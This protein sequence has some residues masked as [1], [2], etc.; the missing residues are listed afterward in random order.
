[1]SISIIAHPSARARWRRLL[2][3]HPSLHRAAGGPLATSDAP[4]PPYDP[5]ILVQVL[6]S[7]IADPGALQALR[8]LLDGDKE[9]HK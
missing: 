2:I 7:L 8:D 6:G 5:A 1:V 9:G 4:A 3:D